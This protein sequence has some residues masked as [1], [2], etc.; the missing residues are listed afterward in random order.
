MDQHLQ[1]CCTGPIVIDLFRLGTSLQG[2][3]VLYSVLLQQLSLPGWQSVLAA[4]SQPHGIGVVAALFD[5]EAVPC[6][7]LSA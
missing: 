7:C 1:Q 6:T 2:S 3:C 4:T 5:H